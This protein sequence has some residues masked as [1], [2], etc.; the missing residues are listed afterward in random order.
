MQT[1]SETQGRTYDH[2]QPLGVV[3]KPWCNASQGPALWTVHPQRMVRSARLDH[4][5]LY[6]RE[7]ENETADDDIICTILSLRAYNHHVV[8]SSINGANGEATGSDDLDAARSTTGNP[9]SGVDA[10]L[11]Q[12]S[13]IVPDKELRP[14]KTKADKKRDHKSANSRKHNSKAK[15]QPVE[16]PHA[17]KP[18]VPLDEKEKP[19]PDVFFKA[20]PAHEGKPPAEKEMSKRERKLAE[21]KPAQDQAE[22]KIFIRV[23][24][25]LLS[26]S[27][28]PI[29]WRC[30]LFTFCACAYMLTVDFLF[31]DHP[32]YIFCT[33]AFVTC[34]TYFFYKCVVRPLMHSQRVPTNQWADNQR[35]PVFGFTELD[36]GT[37]WYTHENLLEVNAMLRN[38]YNAYH[39]VTY[40]KEIMEFLTHQKHG[41]PSSFSQ[42]Q[43]AS[44]A[45][46][47]FDHI[48][49]A[50]V[51][52][53]AT[54]HHQNLLVDHYKYALSQG[55]VDIGIERM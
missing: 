13:G 38:G 5:Q 28:W 39:Y 44:Y 16:R 26:R 1:D 4:S 2:A 40:S 17:D 27:W 24:A 51:K 52:D 45:L 12:L 15:T 19:K 35:D 20:D 14:E 53:T 31:I 22:C 3:H 23:P 11:R 36:L 54:V 18:L 50:I 8:S 48:D 33:L 6:E 41:K 30:V 29:A 49:A 47:E 42:Q 43:Y 7:R 55:D 25:H 46:R 34:A 21:Y 32:M 9:N 10:G 37:W